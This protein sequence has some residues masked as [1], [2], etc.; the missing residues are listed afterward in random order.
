MMRIFLIFLLLFPLFLFASQPA[1]VVGV[2]PV[3]FN[4]K[5]MH[6]P[7]PYNQ[8]LMQRGYTRVPTLNLPFTFEGGGQFNPRY[9]PTKVTKK[10]FARGLG[11]L[12][13]RIGSMSPAS[14][15]LLVA[16]GAYEANCI[17][18]NY[19]S[20]CIADDSDQSGSPT[21]YDPADFKPAY[22][23][24][25]QFCA[26]TSPPSGGSIRVYA[27]AE[28]KGHA[29]VVSADMIKDELKALCSAVAGRRNCVVTVSNT[30]ETSSTF[31]L[32][33]DRVVYTHPTTKE[34]TTTPESLPNYRTSSFTFTVAAASHVCP[35]T[36]ENQTE[37][38]N[39]I[40]AKY[41]IGPLSTENGQVCFKPKPTSIPITP[42]WIEEQFEQN[43][44]PVI[45]SDIGLDDFVDWETGLPRPDAF[46]N[47][48]LDPVSDAFADAA[49][50]IANGTVQHTNPTGQ[51]Y[52]PAEMMPNL[53]VQ[54]NNWHEGDTFVDVF[55]GKTITPEAP[56]PEKTDI[57]W[58]KFPG[59]TKAQYEASNNA[60]GSA[61]TSGKPDINSEID[62]LTQ[63]QQ[64]L[65][66]FINEP[67]PNLPYEIDFPA[68]FQLPTSG[69]CRGFTVTG[70]IRGVSSPIV[71]DKHCPP[72]EAWGR[73]VIEWFLGIMTIFQCFHIFRR[74]IEVA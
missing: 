47:P 49:E 67:T 19:P 70:S 9:Q 28:T 15:A 68:L 71:V 5:G 8:Q 45:D 63:E 25:G 58:S 60:W 13:G 17:S 48:T 35:P 73:P 46:E 16:Y 30:T 14:K 4:S 27:C 2:I 69:Q 33:F 26:S 39:L 65:T 53:L 59:I 56:P 10:S 64:K 6:A 44:Q 38:E 34:E 42:E 20:L 37:Q 29:V 61:A 62:K 43:P 55:N 54:I 7:V 74:T 40:L 36:N 21:D 12:A 41:T 22:L 32:N 3:K 1:K 11:Y 72:Y 66:D 31:S 52:V 50:A 18:Q 23:K 24:S 57:D 51:G